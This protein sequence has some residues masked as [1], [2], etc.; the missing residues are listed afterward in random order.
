MSKYS[1]GRQPS[2]QD[3][4]ATVLVWLTLALITADGVVSIVLILTSK[5]PMRAWEGG[6]PLVP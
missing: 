1:E 2:R 6:G 3:A 5:S 4:W